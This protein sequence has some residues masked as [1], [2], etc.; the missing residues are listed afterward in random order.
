MCFKVDLLLEQYNNIENINSSEDIIYTIYT[1][2]S[3]GNPKGTSLIHQNVYGLL[4]SIEHDLDLKICP[5]DV[6]MSLLKYSFDAIIL[7]LL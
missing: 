6:S 4:Y 2:G 7:G 5:D 3:T 1:S